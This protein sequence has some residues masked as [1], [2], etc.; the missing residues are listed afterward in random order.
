MVGFDLETTGPD[1]ETA[2]IVQAAVA[3]V[4]GGL[5]PEGWS[6]LCDPGVPIP[7]EATAVHGITDE[8]V[9]AEGV[10]PGEVLRA[11]VVTLG[12]YLGQGL[13]LVAFNARYDLTVF[14]REIRRYGVE[15]LGLYERLGL[16]LYV[17]DPFVIDK[18]LDRYRKGSRK[19]DAICAQYGAT[20]DEAH[21]ADSD[22]LAACRAA[23]VLGAKGRVIR[24]P[25]NWG[26]HY[27]ADLREAKAL[28]AEWERVRCDLDAL[29]AAQARWAAA[30][31]AHLADYWRE[32]ITEGHEVPGD[33]DEVRGEWPLIPAVESA[34]VTP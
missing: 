34:T 18:W 6:A 9:R 29:H 15:P 16:P 33:P 24:K 8:M 1:P 10:P 22:A 14:D 30:D 32:R 13:P 4:G 19:L 11:L 26:G 31:A 21:A 25:R 17:I 28:A 5:A 27:A 7:E 12:P 3:V 23:W 20:L 2:R